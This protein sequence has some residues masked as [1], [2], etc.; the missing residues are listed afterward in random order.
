VDDSDPVMRS[1]YQFQ[2]RTFWVGLLY[3]VSATLLCM[4]LIGFPLLA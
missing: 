3:L 1:H 2:I 4:V